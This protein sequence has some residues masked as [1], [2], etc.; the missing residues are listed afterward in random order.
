MFGQILSMYPNPDDDVHYR[1]PFGPYVPGGPV[2]HSAWSNPMPGMWGGGPSPQPWSLGPL[3]DPWAASRLTQAVVNHFAARQELAQL[4]GEEQAARAAADAGKAIQKF[5]DDFCGTGQRLNDLIAQWIARL[6][7]GPVPVPPPRPEWRELAAIEKMAIGVQLH[8][9]AG[10]LE[11]SPLQ[12]P[13]ALAGKSAMTSG[14]K[15]LE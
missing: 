4:V 7:L 10:Y 12:E 9:A 2:L 15:G 1:G 8:L 13:C 5:V 11:G 3:P 6:H 14:L